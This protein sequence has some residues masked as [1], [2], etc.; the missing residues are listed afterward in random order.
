MWSSSGL[1]VPVIKCH[2]YLEAKENPRLSLNSPSPSS[3][4]PLHPQVSRSEL[5]SQIQPLLSKSYSTNQLLSPGLLMSPWP[6]LQPPLCSL[7]CSPNHLL[8]LKSNFINTTPLLHPFHDL[9]QSLRTLGSTSSPSKPSPP[10]YSGS[11]NSGELLGCSTCCS[12]KQEAL[13]SPQLLFIN[14]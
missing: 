5:L 13:P 11:S 4:H 9:P 12:M 3:P 2:S 14:F 7:Y 8:K 10:F 1:P 6:L